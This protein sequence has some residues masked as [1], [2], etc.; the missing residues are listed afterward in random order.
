MAILGHETLRR[1]ICTEKAPFSSKI[2]N[3]RVEN[4]KY[5]I[6][7]ALRVIPPGSAYKKC[8]EDWKKHWDVC[9]ALNGTY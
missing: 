1:T 8:F 9:A 6:R 5:K 7:K 2:D 4:D 3:R